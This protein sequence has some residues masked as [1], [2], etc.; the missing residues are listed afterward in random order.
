MARWEALRQGGEKLRIRDAAERLGV[1]E[2]QLIAIQVDGARIVR[3][4]P[5]F[6][7]IFEALEER[8]E[9]M[10]STR[11][12]HAVIEKHGVYRGVEIGKIVGLVLDKEIDLRLFMGQFRSA[13]YV[14]KEHL[15]K[16]LKSIQFFDA[17]GDSIHKIYAKKTESQ[18]VLAELVQRFRDEDQT[19]WQVSE[20][21]PVKLPESNDEDV[22]VTAFQQGWLG[23]QDTHE[24]FGLL[25]THGLS[26]TQ[27]L[28]LAPEGYATAIGDTDVV[29]SLLE[30]SAEQELPIMVFVGSKGCIEI[31]TGVVRKIVE[32]GSWLNVLDPR[33]NLHLDMS[34]VANIWLVRKPTEDGIVTSLELFDEAGET[35][36][37]FFGERKPGVPELDAWRS[38]IEDLCGVSPITH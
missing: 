26:R 7:E 23:L 25:R 20:P 32:M 1:S 29:Q 19:P 4:Q 2:A 5:Q 10:V 12:A 27:A 8:G 6:K 28:R 9:F 16:P 13:Y 36:A 15:G 11:N 24:F 37:M 21:R 14:E 35:I 34:G 33:F 22:D 30:T 3:L 17:A 18:E 38:L 31:H